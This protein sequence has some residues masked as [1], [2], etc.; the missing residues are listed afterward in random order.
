MKAFLNN[1]DFDNFLKNSIQDS[2]MET[3]QNSWEKLRLQ[4]A[5]RNY[6][7]KIRIVYIS[8]SAILI[9]AVLAIAFY[10]ADSKKND[11]I[12]TSE[13]EKS[14]NI[15]NVSSQKSN[16]QEQNSSLN[17]VTTKVKS[18]NLKE[19]TL[20][21]SSQ[22]NTKQLKKEKNI[23]NFN[24]DKKVVAPVKIAESSKN[25]KKQDVSIEQPTPLVETTEAS[26]SDSTII[27]I[28]DIALKVD[29][30]DS[31]KTISQ[32]PNLN[33]S[34]DTLIETADISNSR[35]RK[36]ATNEFHITAQYTYNSTWILNQNT[37]GQFG[38]KELA[39]ENDFGSAIGIMAGYDIRRAHGFQ[40]GFIFRSI[41]GQK[42]HDVFSIGEFYREIDFEYI[43]I[44][45]V[46]KLKKFLSSNKNPIILNLTTGVQYGRLLKAK[47]TMNGVETDILDRFNKNEIGFVLN[48]ESDFYL[49]NFL[50]FTFGLNSS[51]SNNI[52][53]KDWPVNDDYKKSHNILVG[54][55]LGLSY[56]FGM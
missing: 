1:E 52:N 44:P 55:N 14:S 9:S 18:N 4:K 11:Y 30:I 50:Y 15:N 42:Y 21:I 10:F 35:K 2:E 20:K 33:I 29:T 53:H 43:H 45:L 25:D 19:N 8:S 22:N 17:D 23:S 34:I 13:I 38:S 3:P 49:N 7:R 41:Q 36:T 37:Y 27:A 12:A 56:Y 26:K 32:N 28:S 51:F 47:E 48:I 24:Y 39:Y 31:L 40:T 46:L 54:A 6:K 5:E 16:L